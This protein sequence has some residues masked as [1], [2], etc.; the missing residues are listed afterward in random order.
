VQTALPVATAAPEDL[1][2]L[3]LEEVLKN[4][5]AGFGWDRVNFLPRSC[6]VLDLA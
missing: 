5:C 4:G 3:A 2:N 6:C 1:S